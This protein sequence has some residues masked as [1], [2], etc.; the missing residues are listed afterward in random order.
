MICS[1]SIYLRR[2]CS[3][4]V[5][6]YYVQ[7]YP[8]HKQP[9]EQHFQRSHRKLRSVGTVFAKT[10][11]EKNHTISEEMEVAVNAYFEACFENS[12]RNI[13]RDSNLSYGSRFI[14]SLRKYKFEPYKFRPVQTL[15]VWYADRRI[16]FLTLVC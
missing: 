13:K 5:K 14:R 16:S 1:K 12:V 15:L 6:Q 3:S 2:K 4:N 10:R 7:L 11:V 8:D 9:H